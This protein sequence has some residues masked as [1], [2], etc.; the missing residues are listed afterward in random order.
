MSRR[1]EHDG[2]FPS[3]FSVN[4]KTAQERF[5]EFDAQHPEVYR[6]FRRFAEELLE[7]GCEHGSA[8]QIVQRIR[9]EMSLNREG[10]SG[11]RFNNWFR[12]H[13]A[14]KLAA[15][16]ARFADFFEFRSRRAG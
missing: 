13:Y 2:D 14:R 10:D 1:R 16:D 5:A 4:S 11:F 15:E 7:S 9:W 8:E 3:L 6:M 12:A